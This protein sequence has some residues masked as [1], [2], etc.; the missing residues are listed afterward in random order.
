MTVA[1]LKREVLV[2]HLEAWAPAALHRARRATYV[3][4]YA[5]S[6]GGAS[7][8]AALRVFVEQ[9]DLVRGRELTVLAIGA[10]V[11][12][13]APRLAVPAGAAGLTVHP[14][15]GATAELLGVALK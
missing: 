9:S 12:A 4:G 7:A 1:E 3:H 5:D 11:A 14:V 10:D 15:A 2:R 6:D 13:L 8:E